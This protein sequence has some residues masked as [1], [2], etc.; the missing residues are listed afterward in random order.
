MRD[1]TSARVGF[2]PARRVPSAW[3]MVKACLVLRKVSRSLGD[4]DDDGAKLGLVV[5]IFRS[6]NFDEDMR[7]YFD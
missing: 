3:S 2:G 1:S 6:G 5:A 4:G 7:T